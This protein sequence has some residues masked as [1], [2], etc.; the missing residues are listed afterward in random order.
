VATAMPMRRLAALTAGGLAAGAL[1]A[2][3][4][5]AAPAQAEPTT[6]T[7]TI[8]KSF[9]YNCDI[10]ITIPDAPP[11]QSGPQP[12]GNFV[13]GV[14]A[15]SSVPSSI[16]A[17]TSV[18]PTPATIT[19][20]MPDM[21]WFVTRLTTQTTAVNGSSSD[22]T[23]GFS[24]AG[25]RTDVP[26]DGLSV[27]NAP[28]PVASA[29][30]ET[31]PVTPWTIPTSGTVRAI[32]VPA[33]A[34]GQSATLQMPHHFTADALLLNGVGVSGGAMNFPTGLD[35]LLPDEASD[36][37]LVAGQTIPITAAPSS[38]SAS[39]QPATYGAAARLSY[40]VK[41]ATAG[42]VQVL[43]GA[44]I[45]ANGVV[46]AQGRGSVGVA[47]LAVGRHT[48][49]V[50][51]AGTETVLASQGSTTFTVAKAASSIGSVSV[52]PKKIKAKKTAAKLV[53]RVASPA[54]AATG[55]VTVKLK[56]KTVGSAALKGGKA[57]V[58]LKKFAKKGKQTLTVTYGGSATVVGASK[59]VKVTVK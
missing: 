54:G 44:K 23:I 12:L 52:A 7:I 10:S 36:A 41:N 11:E 49:T 3:A 4:L 24:I 21:L 20:S 38:V 17:G 48:L 59:T 57:T 14:R 43:E 35:C 55:T 31:V 1:S 22:S 18:A 47:G 29:A 16:P 15:Q 46:D 26:I 13:V 58:K 32:P 56:G 6:G 53:V 25:H 39:V 28:L 19:L 27:S 5:G 45:V 51:Y 37:L 40:A 30:D 50:K 42:T 2:L 9:D 34:A 33:A 8:D